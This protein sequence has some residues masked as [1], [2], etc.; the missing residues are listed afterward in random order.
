MF[1]RHNH[2][3]GLFVPGKRPHVPVRLWVLIWVMRLPFPLRL[4]LAAQ[5]KLV[6]P[7]LQVVYRVITRRLLSQARL[8]P[9]GADSGAFTLIQRFGSAANLNIHLHCLMLD[10]VCRRSADGAPAFVEAPAPTDEALQT[11]LHKIITRM[12]PAAHPSR[13]VGR[14][15]GFDLHGRQQADNDGD[16]DAARTFRPLQAAGCAYRIAF[17]PRAGQK[18][19]TLQGAM[20]R[21]T[22]FKLTQPARSR[23][24][25]G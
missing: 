24:L 15:G 23:A 18:L 10:G 16:L 21:Q 9:D 13:G 19:L 8:N 2:S 20:P 6:T 7:V 5:P 14:K 17:D 3:P 25:R 4:L 1:A 22:D 12:T 11:V